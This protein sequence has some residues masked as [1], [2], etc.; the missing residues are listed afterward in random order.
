VI[1]RFGLWQRPR[2]KTITNKREQSAR[3]RDKGGASMIAPR[4]G[5]KNN[6]AAIAWKQ[7][8]K[9]QPQRREP[10]GPDRKRDADGQGDEDDGAESLTIGEKYDDE[11]PDADAASEPAQVYEAAVAL[12]TPPAEAA[13]VVAEVTDDGAA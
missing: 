3:P 12:G 9:R 10:A 11:T 7:P 13:E 2:G 1:A 5:N 4:N 6:G 8:T